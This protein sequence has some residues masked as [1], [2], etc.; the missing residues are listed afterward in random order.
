MAFSIFVN[1]PTKNGENRSLRLQMSTNYT[2]VS[3]PLS[4]DAILEKGLITKFSLCVLTRQK[5]LRISIILYVTRLNRYETQEEE[6]KGR[7][8]TFYSSSL[9][10]E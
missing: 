9:S 10:R 5:V 6:S 1:L 8:F 4:A 3:S 2:P 7:L